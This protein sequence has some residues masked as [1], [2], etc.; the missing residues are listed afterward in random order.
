MSNNSNGTSKLALL[1]QKRS[2]QKTNDEEDIE[3]AIDGFAMSIDTQKLMADIAQNSALVNLIID[4]SYSMIGTPEAIA[5][6]L[7]EFAMRQSGKLYETKLSITM[8]N[9]EVTSLFQNVTCKQFRIS[10]W[11]CYD[12]TNIFDAVIVA[13]SAVQKIDANHKLHLVIT[14]GKNIHSNHS[15]EEVRN[16]IH[17]RIQ[18]GD[19]IFLLYNNEYDNSQETS[20]AYA[21][22]LGIPV[23]NAVNFNR[24]GDG[25]KIIFQAIETLLDGLRS[26]GTVPKDWAKAIIAHNTNPLGIKARETK[27]LE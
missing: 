23:N 18:D 21:E 2:I 10:P 12:D 7:N 8:F 9:S 3:K 1:R 13:I 5:R 15:L 11:E 27:Y 14:D 26:T 22:K 20:K 19:H 24:T 17:Q 25:I 4:R 16:L 6:E